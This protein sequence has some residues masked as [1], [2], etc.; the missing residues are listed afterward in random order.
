MIRA[1]MDTNVILDA[2]LERPPWDLNAKTLWQIQSSDQYLT[3]IVLVFSLLKK[4][5]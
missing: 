2:L 3:T 4:C 5:F 1:L